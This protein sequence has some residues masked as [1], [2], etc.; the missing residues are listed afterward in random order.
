MQRN[1]FLKLIILG[2]LLVAVFAIGKGLFYFDNDEAADLSLIS[3]E[4]VAQVNGGVE[5]GENDLPTKLIIPKLEVES[6]VQRLGVTDTGNM[7]APNNFTDVSWYKFGTVPGYKGSAVMAGHEDNAISLPGVFYNLHK[8][9]IGDD[10]YVLQEDG[11][12]LHFKVIDEQIY[13]YDDPKPL[14]KIFNRA[15]G[16]YLNLITCAGEWLA[17]A[18][19]NDRR[20]VIYAQL[21]E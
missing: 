21:V 5:P 12:R 11:T 7:A 8:L 6:D 19:T 16:T 9:E 4:Q 13:R 15:D 3:G 10:I 20:L 14:E 1:N 17:S 2:A 18:K